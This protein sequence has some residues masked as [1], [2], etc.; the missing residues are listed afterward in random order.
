MSGIGQPDRNS[1]ERRT[2]RYRMAIKIGITIQILIYLYLY[3]YIYQ[4]S[5]PMGDGMEWV[6]VMPASFFLAV[7]A[8]PAH[9]LSKRGRWLPF[10]VLLAA[11]GVII[12]V[13]FFFEIAREFAESAAR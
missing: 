13:A 10:A 4:H 6:A 1:D 7:G 2:R 5:N 9:A 3:V 12:N 11:I 8:A